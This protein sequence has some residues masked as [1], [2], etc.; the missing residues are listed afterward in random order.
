MNFVWK[1]DKLNTPIGRY[2]DLYIGEER[3]RGYFVS[4]NFDAK[5]IYGIT[6][7]DDLACITVEDAKAWVESIYLLTEGS[8]P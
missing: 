2:V 7:E 1:N 4:N 8:K 6:P 5:R 3:A